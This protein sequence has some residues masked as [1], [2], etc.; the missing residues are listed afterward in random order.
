MSVSI[1]GLNGLLRVFDFQTTTTGF[2]YTLPSGYT[3][4][5]F[6]PAATLASGTVT[7]PSSPSD[8]MVVTIAS[9]QVITALSLAGN[10]GQS[11]VNAITTLLAGG[12]ASFV[13]RASNSTWYKV[14]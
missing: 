11:I 4:V 6:T 5:V 3:G 9:T 7:M 1:N 8:G 12:A 10:T 14:A 13:Y 2:S